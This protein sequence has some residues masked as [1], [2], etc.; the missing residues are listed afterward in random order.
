MG[1]GCCELKRDIGSDHPSRQERPNV[2]GCTSDENV[3]PESS[4]DA[5]GAKS[6]GAVPARE[7]ND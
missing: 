3:V 4:D 6:P 1:H 5:A 7:E 2:Y